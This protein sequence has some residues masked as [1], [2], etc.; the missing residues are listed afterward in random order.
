VEEV[1]TSGKNLFFFNECFDLARTAS[2][3]RRLRELCTWRGRRK[4]QQLAVFVVF[5]GFMHPSLKEFRQF[6]QTYERITVY[7]EISG[8]MDTP[9]SMLSRLLSS[10]KALLLESANQNKTYSRFSFLA[11]EVA[12]KLVLRE[13][14]VY[15][16]H[17]RVGGM[18]AMDE[19]LRE[20]KMPVEEGFGD[21]RG[22]YV[23][24][25]NFEF[26]GKC[27]VLKKPLAKTGGQA[28]GTFYLVEKFL[29]YDNYTNSIYLAMSRI[30]DDSEPDDAY[31]EIARELDR[32]E[33]QIRSLPR[34]E[35]TPGKPRITRDIPRGLFIDKVTRVRE[36]I[37]EGEGIQVV[38]S[39]FLEAEGIEP[40][41][42]YRNLRRINPSPYMYF[43]KDG[44]SYIVGSSPEIHARIRDRKAILK[45][46]A[47]TRRRDPSVDLDET[48]ASLRGDEKERAEHLMLVDLARNDLSRI[49]A[50][51]SVEVKSF[52]NPE[53]YSHVVHLVSEVDGDLTEGLTIFDALKQTFPAGTVSGAPKVRAIEIIDELEDHP[54]GAYAGCIGYIGFNGSVDMA[55]TIRTAVFAGKKARLQAGAGI[56][57]DSVPEKEYDEVMNKLLALLKSGGLA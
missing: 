40:F 28:I 22:G 43:L 1:N 29:V 55:I 34:C 27:D 6:W 11:F 31:R 53:V 44:D 3:K 36:M 39:D 20:N 2:K 9:V 7:K 47:G 33:E 24:C 41:E 46:I 15:R 8:D 26:V 35:P 10:D 16:G 12:D 23:G 49:C 50:V 13:D 51:G 57:Y 5:G 32:T 30:R 21:F 45:P 52:M 42:F 17:E 48:I 38:L 54:R 19:I 4:P 56:V 14:G 37:G 25:L 18:S